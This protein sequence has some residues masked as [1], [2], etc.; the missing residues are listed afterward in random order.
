M[1]KL[2][3]KS[4]LPDH[5][6]AKIRYAKRY[7]SSL[8]YMGRRFKCPICCGHFR[9]FLSTGPN[10]RKN[11]KS[12]GHHSLERHRLIWMFLKE[13]TNFFEAKLKVSH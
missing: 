8:L 9:T 7:I 10:Q 11:A 13:K 4:L 6:A 1:L 3:I 5:Y 12:P 2:F